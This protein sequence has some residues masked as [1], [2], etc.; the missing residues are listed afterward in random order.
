MGLGLRP[1]WKVSGATRPVGRGEGPRDRGRDIAAGLRA[2]AGELGGRG[3]RG[4]ELYGLIAL[5]LLVC[6]DPLIPDKA[7]AER[8]GPAPALFDV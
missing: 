8:E 4:E 1:P 7:D 5:A 2:R 6:P 3:S